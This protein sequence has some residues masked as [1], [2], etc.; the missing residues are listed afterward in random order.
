MLDYLGIIVAAA[1][2]NNV[3]LVQFLGV[4]SF[5][6][7]SNRL[8]PAIELGLLSFLT[9]FLSSAIN[10]LLYRL[11]LAPLNLDILRLIVFVIVSSLVAFYLVK[12]VANRYPLSWRRHEL[13]IS[14]I[15][16]NSAVIGVS[17]MLSTSIMSVSAALF[18]CFGAALGFAL[19]LICFAALRQR[20]AYGETPRPFQGAPIQLISAGIIAMALLG[21]AGLV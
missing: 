6:A 19:I 11:I 1:L 16:G 20:L 3:A 12:F 5:F 17:L 18:Y 21:F 7:N 4:S 14:L 10:L 8:Q 2:V 13:A 15:A 9:L